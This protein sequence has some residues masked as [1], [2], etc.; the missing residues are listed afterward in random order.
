VTEAEIDYY[1]TLLEQAR[2]E[3]NSGEKDLMAE[4]TQALLAVDESLKTYPQPLE[5]SCS[6]S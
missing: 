2:A 4:R 3:R 5:V 6:R 1:S